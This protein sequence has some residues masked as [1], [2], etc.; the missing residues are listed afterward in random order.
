M[1]LLFLFIFFAQFSHGQMHY[2]TIR[3]KVM[4][5]N[6]EPGMF[7]KIVAVDSKD[8]S[9]NFVAGCQSDFDGYFQLNALKAGEYDLIFSSSEHDTLIV[10][11]VL[12]QLE[13]ITFVDS[14][15]MNNVEFDCSNCV[16]ME[17]I[18]RT[19]E[20]PFGRFT[21]IQPEDIRRD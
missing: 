20:D 2:G 4:D 17:P 8:S 15:T 9:Q 12:V 10:E 7:V 21:T 3:G 16:P 13:R 18:R 11:D 6:G 19:F 1:K 14:V 5:K